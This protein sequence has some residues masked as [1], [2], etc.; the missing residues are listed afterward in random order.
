MYG[1]A[2][3]MSDNA[4][5][6]NDTLTGGFSANRFPSENDLYGDAY[7]MFDNSRGGNDTLTGATSLALPIPFMATPT[8][9]PTTPAAAT[10]R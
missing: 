5:G 4:L 9:C 7:S 6:G 8:L 3:D 2:F 1:D 10:T